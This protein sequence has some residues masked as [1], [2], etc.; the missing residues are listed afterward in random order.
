MVKVMTTITVPDF[1]KWKPGFVN[2]MASRHANGCQETIIYRNE[3]DLNEVIL[4]QTWEST[5]NI[6]VF[7]NNPVYTEARS[8]AGVSKLHYY[9]LTLVNN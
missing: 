4:V 5:D 1:E 7:L 8:K 3:Q 2:G 9:V 6:K